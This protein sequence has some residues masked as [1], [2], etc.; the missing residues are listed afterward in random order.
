[1]YQMM[2]LCNCKTTIDENME[3]LYRYFLLESKKDLCIDDNFVNIQCYGIEVVRE[4]LLDG[5][6]VDIDRDKIETISPI[7]NKVVDLIEY[8]K[9]HEVSPVHLVDIIG[10]YVDESV[11]DFED[12]AR[13]QLAKTVL[14]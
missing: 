2:E 10:E 12:E 4:K 11:G 13:N 6:I 1:M 9:D 14:A 3:Y 8:L 5:R 7:R